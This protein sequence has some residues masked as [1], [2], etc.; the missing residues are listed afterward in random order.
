M[1]ENQY[2]NI[3]K[4]EIDF[5][6]PLGIGSKG[7]GVKRVQE[8]LYHHNVGT[9]IDGDY[10]PATA[11]CVKHFQMSNELPQ[12]GTVD[13]STWDRLVTPL[14]SALADSQGTTLAERIHSVAKQHLAN[15]P[16]EYGGDNRGPWV[17][18]YTG[19][20]DGP[21]WF[22]CAGFVSFIIEQAGI[23]LGL[24]LPIAGSLSCNILASQAQLS[25]HLVREADLLSDK[26]AWTSLGQTYIFLVR[27]AAGDYS[28]TGIGFGGTYDVF[29]TIEG[30]T[31]DDGSKNGYEVA[32]RTRS[33]YN[34]DFI[35]I[36]GE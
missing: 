35:R 25:G 5:P 6:G 21:E 12:S 24:S 17:R 34:K 9:K 22:W 33:A 16:R 13:Q 2:S 23:E 14:I 7:E 19:G 15:H 11:C 26:S 10:G 32:G 28:H 20:Y 31:N 29:Q 18:V 27:R 4:R 1:K 3:I 36:I 30:N 8:W